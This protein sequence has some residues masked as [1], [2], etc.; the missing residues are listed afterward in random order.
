MRRRKLQSA[1]TVFFL[2]AMFVSIVALPCLSAT[3][4]TLVIGLLDNV[5]SLDPAKS[6]VTTSWGMMSQTYETLVALNKDDVTQVVPQLAESWDISADGKTW[7]FHL[8]KDAAFSTGNPANADAVVFSLLRVIKLAYAPSWL[9]SQFGITD[10]TISKID[11]ST[12]Q[13]TLDKVYAPSL[14]L[15]CL[16]IPVASIIDPSVMEHDQNGDMGSTW[17]EEH[18]LGSNAYV[19]KERKRDTPTEYV[20]EANQY[21]QQSTKTFSRVIVK[22]IQDAGEQLSLLE[23]GDIDIAWNLQPFQTKQAMQNSQI[24]IMQTLAP[25][26]DYLGM[27][28]TYAPLSKSEVRD[29]IRYAI[30]YDGLIKGIL[31][32]AAQKIQTFIPQGIIGYNPT[33]LY[34]R[35]IAKA[36]QL[37]VDAGYPNG[38]DVE[39]KCY[40]FSPW[41]EIAMKVKKDLSEIGVNVTINQRTSEQLIAET[42]SDKRDFQM[43]LIFWMGDYFDPDAF[44]KGFAHSDSDGEDATIKL[45]AWW[46]HY[47][48][49]ETS[50]LVDQAVLE[51]DSE[52]RQALYNIVTDMI[53]DDG[54]FVILDSP[55]RVFGIR[56]EVAEFIGNPAILASDFPSIK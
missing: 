22:G 32:G 29:A 7:I 34:N 24:E 55:L 17:L 36:K 41:I 4:D 56:K 37:L 45:G 31:Q 15:S 25:Q 35:D 9:I 18:S 38:F 33:I 26:I 6:Y 44:A 47:V 10:Q 27:N 1:W 3:K 39:L 20:M 19:L 2:T 8:R 30:D 52:K 28:I 49:K 51:V 16:T 23:Q 42:W 5:D 54:P 53:L 43:V 21:Y 14:F 46:C 40:N 12:V 48:N 50:Q 11:E 13:I